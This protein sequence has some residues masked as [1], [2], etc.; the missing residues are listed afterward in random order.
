MQQKDLDQVY[1]MTLTVS[2]IER[3]SDHA[4]NIIEY[5]Q[6]LRAGSAVLSAQA[7]KELRSMCQL[8]LKSAEL[9]LQIFE[10]Q[11]YSR[12]PEAEALESQVDAAR[13]QL[14]QNHIKRLME[15]SCEPRGGVLFCDMVTDL[16]RCSDHAINIAAALKSE[17]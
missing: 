3:L 7:Q 10:T 1:R 9:C 14:V 6:Q 17:L 5:A 12:F 13:E 11:D 16:E 2:D 8:T 4:T 15:T